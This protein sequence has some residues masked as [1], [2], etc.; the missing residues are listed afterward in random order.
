MFFEV[1]LPLSSRKIEMFG[2][3]L[4]YL[5]NRLDGFLICPPIRSPTQKINGFSG[6]SS[7]REL[8]IIENFSIETIF[9]LTGMEN[10]D[11]FEIIKLE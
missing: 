7:L 3:G 10:P 9:Q 5:E 2:I 4:G 6:F 1:G 11:I 8:S